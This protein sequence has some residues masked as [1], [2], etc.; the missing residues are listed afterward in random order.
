ML[1]QNSEENFFVAL[2]ISAATISEEKTNLIKLDFVAGCF[3]CG[4]ND[5]FR[6]FNTDPLKEK[7][8]QV[9]DGGIGGL[10]MLFRCNYLALVGGGQKPFLAPNKLLVW[11]DLKKVP[12]I[13]LDFN[14]PIRAVRLRRDRIVVV[15]GKFNRLFTSKNARL[16]S[17]LQRESSKFSHSHKRLNSFSSSRLIKIQMD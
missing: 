12:A 16:H 1:R 10:E 4:T 2:I 6:V 3:A 8:R 17:I 11:D 13:S 9:L 5:G 14:G 7:E 15:L